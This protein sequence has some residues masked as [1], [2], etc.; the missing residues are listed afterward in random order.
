VVAL[1]VVDGEY[2]IS[3]L[4]PDAPPPVELLAT[5]GFVC[6]AKT[7]DE[8]SIVSPEPITRAAVETGWTLLRVEGPLDFALVG[9]L[10]SLTAPLADASISVFAISTYDTDYLLVRT[11]QLDDTVAALRRAGHRIT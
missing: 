2:N 6:I 1:R 9:I 11:V 3:R 7:Q 10:A 8:I 5:D 4:P